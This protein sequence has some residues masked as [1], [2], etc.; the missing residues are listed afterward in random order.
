MRGFGLWLVG[1]SGYVGSTTALGLSAMR[2]GLAPTDGLVTE[3]R[4][5]QWADLVG[6]DRIVLGGHEI[7]PACGSMLETCGEFERLIQTGVLGKCR[8]DLRR[9][10][11]NLRPGTTLGAGSGRRGQGRSPKSSA[12]ASTDASAAAAIERLTADMTGFRRAHKLENVVVINVAGTE[13]VPKS[14]RGAAT[15]ANLQKTLARRGASPLP[16]SSLYALA[17]I[18]AGAA[19]INFTPSLGIDLP[20]LRRRAE[21]RGL[22]YMGRDGKTGETLV[23]S[24]LAPLFV[25]R[26]LNVL[27]WVGYNLLGNPDGA[28]L[29]DPRVRASKQKSKDLTVAKI[30]AGKPVTR[31]GIDFLPSLGDRKL[32]WDFIHFRGFLGAEMSLQFIWQGVDSLL[33]APLILDLARLAERELRRGAP[34]PM[35]H[36]ACFFKDP[37]TVAQLAM[38]DQW[39]LLV[40]HF[41]QR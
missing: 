9:W 19:Y 22:P 32:A 37:M 18:E 27:S 4:A 3:G 41:S 17:A 26:N 38:H 28:A 12:H 7:K 11:K 21:E 14:V 33:A 6:Y 16:T 8:P 10:Q 25:F 24:I 40:K 13:V 31:V 15:W 39:R 5:F 30:L 29:K 34:G 1:A 2:R 20:V 35:R 23:K 36:L